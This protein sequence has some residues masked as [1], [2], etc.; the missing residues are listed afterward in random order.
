MRDAGR[1]PRSAHGMQKQPG[2]TTPLFAPGM[3]YS[4]EIKL[5]SR[6]TGNA[7]SGFA[8]G[9]SNPVVHCSGGIGGDGTCQRMQ[10]TG[11]GS[12]MLV[13]GMLII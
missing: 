13:Y 9:V 1:M 10:T 8:Y 6:K 7:S 12:S 2:F 5:P 3:Q 11:C 4:F